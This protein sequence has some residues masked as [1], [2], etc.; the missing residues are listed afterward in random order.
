MGKPESPKYD[1]STHAAIFAAA[2]V[3]GLMIGGTINQDEKKEPIKTELTSAEIDSCREYARD[4]AMQVCQE[5]FCGKFLIRDIEKEIGTDCSFGV[6]PEPGTDA[7]KCDLKG[8]ETAGRAYVHRG[9]KG[10]NFDEIRDSV[11]SR[12]IAETIDSDGDN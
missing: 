3:G 10:Y 8:L 2:M 11:Y 7:D 12:C 6:I 1:F 4:R 5:I 9:E